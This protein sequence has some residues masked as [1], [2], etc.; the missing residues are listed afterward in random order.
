MFNIHNTI[1]QPAINS[2]QFCSGFLPARG[3]FRCFSARC[4]GASANSRGLCASIK[5]ALLIFVQLDKD[6][7]PIAFIHG[8]VLVHEVRKQTHAHKKGQ[9]IFSFLSLF[10]LCFQYMGGF[11]FFYSLTF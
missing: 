4:G 5:A 10:T 9:S 1:L 6:L 11:G 3:G 8:T 2:G 7:E